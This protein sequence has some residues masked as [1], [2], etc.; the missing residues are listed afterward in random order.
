ML[1]LDREA[2]ICDFAEAYHIYTFKGLSA[3]YIATLAIGLRENSRIKLKMIGVKNCIP[4]IILNALLIDSVRDIRYMLAKYLS[5]ET[6]RGESIVDLIYGNEQS[7][8]KTGYSSVQEFEE[9]REKII[10][11]GHKWR[12]E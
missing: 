12:E 2:V 7:A 4:S 5:L 6:E 1:S 9:A 11:G 3:R 10:K 8:K